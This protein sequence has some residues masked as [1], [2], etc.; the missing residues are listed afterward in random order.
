MSGYDPVAATEALDR[1]LTADTMLWSTDS[2]APGTHRHRQARDRAVLEALKSGLSP[3]YVADKL[4]VQINDVE[5][6]A[7][8]ATDPG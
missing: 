8:S 7:G 4:G 6:M 3:E 5:R 2:A 1:A